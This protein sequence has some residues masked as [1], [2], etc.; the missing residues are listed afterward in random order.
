MASIIKGIL[1]VLFS[2]MLITACSLPVSTP[3]G[4]A[5][6]RAVYTVQVST[7]QAL[8]TQAMSSS[9]QTMPPTIVFPTLPPTIYV[10]TQAP[11]IPTLQPTQL[12]LPTLAPLSYCDWVA[13]VK[14]VTVP[15]GTVLA[16][17]EKFTK[18]WRLRN[19]GNCTWTKSY[20]LAFVSGN[21]MK[22]P[23][24]VDMPAKI[25]PG[26]SVD[27]SVNLTAPMVE[28]SYRSN[29]L[30][31]NVAGEA[32]GLGAA[33]NTPFYVDIKV[34]SPTSTML[35]FSTSYCSAV[36]RS[37]AGVLGCPGDVKS[38]KG[39]ATRVENPQLE[40]GQVYSGQGLMVAPETVNNGYIQGYYPAYTVHTGDRFRAQI[41][42]AYLATG[43]LATFRLDYQIGDGP[44]IT[45]WQF[46]EAYEGRTYTVDTDLNPLAG[47][48]VKFILTVLSN[49]PADSDKLLWIAPRIVR[50]SNLVTPTATPTATATQT[51]TPTVTTTFTTT[52]TATS[53]LTPTVTLTQTATNTPTLTA[54]LTPTL[55][56]TSTLTETATETAT[57]TATS[58]P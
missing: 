58:G 5:T 18:T 8:Q 12:V 13:Y 6:L 57:L 10:P 39:Y 38:K 28:G 34:V 14:D 47:N 26:K 3:D 56:V 15:D 4:A 2:S 45:I 51:R 35:D 54:T 1:F 55:I 17:G 40:S 19:I 16:P 21:N 44:V 20:A 43:C 23:A 49:G 31:H 29:W 7:V 36:W 22:G 33:A 11:Q 25:T 41:N 42:C 30:L 9:V 46:A 53:T 27:I 52:A 50:P 32:F 48:S 37:G 24:S